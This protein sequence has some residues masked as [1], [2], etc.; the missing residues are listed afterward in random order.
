MLD[1]LKIRQLSCPYLL[2]DIYPRGYNYH[3]QRTTII[4]VGF[5]DRIRLSGADSDSSWNDTLQNNRLTQD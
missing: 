4:N 5:R 2:Y 1:K 3:H